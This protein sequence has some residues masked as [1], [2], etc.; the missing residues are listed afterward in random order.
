MQQCIKAG[1]P[2]NG[3]PFINEELTPFAGNPDGYYDMCGDPQPGMIQKVW[4][5]QLVEIDP[6]A[7]SA[8]VVLDRRDKQ[9]LFASMNRQARREHLEY[10]AEAAYNEISGT[11]KDYLART[12]IDYFLVYTEDLSLRIGKILEYLA[13]DKNRQG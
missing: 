6:A 2:V 7:I 5:R 9:A 11:L 8:L 3:V 4:P 13:M 10:S 1:L 12:G